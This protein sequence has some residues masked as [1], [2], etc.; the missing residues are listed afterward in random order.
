M[1]ARYVAHERQPEAAALRVM[2][3]RIARSIKLLKDPRL[4]VPLDADTTIAHF[5]FE[6]TLLTI[7]PDAQKFFVVGIFECI[8]NEID[9][10]ACDRFAIDFHRRN[11]WIDML[12][13]RESLLLDLVTIRI[14]SVAHELRDVRLSEVVLLRARLDAREVENVIDQRTEPFTLFANDAVV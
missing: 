11:A 6:H 5:E 13:E 1:R 14:Q 10:R 4:L 12:L 7:K 2:H 8:V 9:K 3:K